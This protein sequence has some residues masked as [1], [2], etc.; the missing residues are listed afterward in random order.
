MQVIYDL[1]K[2]QNVFQPNID[3]NISVQKLLLVPLRVGVHIS[4]LRVQMFWIQ[5]QWV[6]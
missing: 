1:S 5:M 2:S 3:E 6:F 4:V